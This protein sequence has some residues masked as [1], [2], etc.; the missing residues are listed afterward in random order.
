MRS[1]T[2]RVLLGAGAAAAFGAAAGRAPA[3]KAQ[4]A[5]P[6]KVMTFPGLSN[7]PIFVAQEKGFF[8][9]HGIAMEL[10]YTPNSQTQRQGLAEGKHQI[11]HTAA[12]NP[13]AMVEGAKWDAVI[14]TGGDH[15]F[16]Q[17]IVQPE[18][19]ALSEIRGKTVVVDAPN[20]AYA[21]LLY[22]ALKDNGL[23]KGDYVVNPVGGTDQRMEAMTADKKNVAGVMGLP[24]TFRA[25]AAGLKDIGAAHQSIGAYQADCVAVMRDW[26][27]ANSETLVR[28]IKAIVEARRW[29]F[30]N[31]AE[32]TQVLVDRLK[33]S[34]EISART[35][36]I[37]TH[38]TTGMA[39][40][41][42]L[43]MAGFQNVL[44]LRAEIE[45]QWGGNP[46]APEKYLD[47]SYYEKAM[48]GL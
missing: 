4:G 27:K 30:A 10:L 18:I 44:K 45:G 33:L 36:D 47:L 41:A 39:K 26:G 34:P 7:Y 43:D 35:Y 29:I 48:A 15:G 14:V 23:N 3:A 32:A 21:F 13:V 2:R 25:A 17:I 46:P 28:Y 8:A 38:P 11:I 37:V 5:A 6:L 1:T 12:D 19:N 9:K 31:K 24:F 42:K 20:T 16:N 40:D 22:K